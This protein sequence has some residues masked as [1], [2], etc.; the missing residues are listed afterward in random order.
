MDRFWAN[1][2]LGGTLPLPTDVLNRLLRNISNI[3]G[4][5]TLGQVPP[6]PISECNHFFINISRFQIVHYFKSPLSKHLY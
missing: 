1:S 6:D 4:Q 3:F 5:I 2:R